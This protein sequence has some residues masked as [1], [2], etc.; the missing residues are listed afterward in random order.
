MVCVAVAGS[1]I[2]DERTRRGFISP[3]MYTI[4]TFRA[5]RGILPLGFCRQTSP[6]P[7]SLALGV[8]PFN[9]NHGIAGEPFGQ[10]VVSPVIN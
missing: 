4:T 1:G 8:V 7:G 3:G 5:A 2:I 10:V 9:M 6:G